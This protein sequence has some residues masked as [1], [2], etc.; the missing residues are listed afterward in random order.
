MAFFSTDHT[1]KKG[2]HV[3]YIVRFYDNPAMAH[4][5]QAQMEPHLEWLKA[6]SEL[7]RIGGALR[8]QEDGP[9]VGALWILESPDRAT[10]E[11]LL[12][13]DPFWVHGLRERYELYSWH[14]GIPD[15]VLI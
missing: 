11:R 8:E 12:R 7:V 9:S 15:Q 5:R 6:N 1:L 3:L 14:K 2:R 4:V 10:A 13:E